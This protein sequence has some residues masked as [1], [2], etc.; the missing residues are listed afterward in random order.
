MDL[1]GGN[2]TVAELLKNPRA[3][4]ILFQEFPMLKNHPMAHLAHRI[5]VNRAIALAGQALPAQ[6]REEILRK[7]SEV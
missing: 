1:R 2:I 3:K 4:A 6:R 7:L 5:T